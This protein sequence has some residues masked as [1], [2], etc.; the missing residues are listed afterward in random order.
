MKGIFMFIVGSVSK[1]KKQSKKN[2]IFFLKKK[3]KKTKSRNHIYALQCVK[4]A[5][6]DCDSFNTK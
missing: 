5:K 4:P 3:S 6:C 2:L 1:K